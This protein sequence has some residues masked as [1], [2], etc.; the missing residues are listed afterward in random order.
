MLYLIIYIFIICYSAV[1]GQYNLMA[2][3]LTGCVHRFSRIKMK[4]VVYSMDVV[5]I[6]IRLNAV[7]CTRQ[8]LPTGHWTFDNRTIGDFS[9]LQCYTGN[10]L[11]TGSDFCI[12]W[13]CFTASHHNDVVLITSMMFI[14]K[15][16]RH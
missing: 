10:V 13:L 5:L 6:F 12:I 15:L 7:R 8:W 11:T 14:H 2:L 16:I 4:A 1:S 9:A 3:Y